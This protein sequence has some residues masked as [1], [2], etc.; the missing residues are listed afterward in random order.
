MLYFYPTEL[1]LKCTFTPPPPAAGPLLHLGHGFASDF[2]CAAVDA[3]LTSALFTYP[4]HHTSPS[5]PPSVPSKPDEISFERLT[6]RQLLDGVALETLHLLRI[7]PPV[8]PKLNKLSSHR[9]SQT[10]AEPRSAKKD[11]PQIATELNSEKLT[12]A[13]RF[14]FTLR[15]LYCASGPWERSIRRALQLHLEHLESD[16]FSVLFITS[17]WVVQGH[18]QE[19]RA[20]FLY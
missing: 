9:R 19:H 1:S 20:E 13:E 17:Q 5:P 12:H 10:A 8:P 15:A 2:E 3:P 4:N 6:E 14:A 11:V 7:D 18:G 16:D